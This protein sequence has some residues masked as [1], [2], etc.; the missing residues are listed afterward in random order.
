MWV[1]ISNFDVQYIKKFNHHIQVLSNA[2]FKKQ[3][4]SEVHLIFILF[5]SFFIFMVSSDFGVKQ[6]VY[7]F[8]SERLS[9]MLY[10]I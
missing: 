1:S 7:F 3:V 9:E 5:F 8:Y 2:Y 6:C 10:F 4:M